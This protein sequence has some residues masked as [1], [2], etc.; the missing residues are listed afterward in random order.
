MYAHTIPI[1]LQIAL[2][3]VSVVCLVATRKDKS[4]N[5]YARAFFF[6]ILGML[7]LSNFERSLSA[8][9]NSWRDLLLGAALAVY[10]GISFVSLS[11]RR[12]AVS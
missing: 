5:H 1:V 4:R 2:L 9:D 12:Q 6:L 11:L 7:A 10:A 8:G 3:I